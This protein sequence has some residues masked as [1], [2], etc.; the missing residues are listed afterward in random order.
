MLAV[1]ALAATL[2]TQLVTQIQARLDA[3]TSGDKAVWARDLDD[4]ALLMDEE[5]HVSTKAQFLAALAPLPKGST[6]S[7]RVTRPHFARTGDVVVIAFIAD[8]HETIYGQHFQAQFGMVDTYHRV[9]D[10]WLLLS[11]TQTRLPL[12]PPVAHL[13][14]AQAQRYVGRYRM[15][16]GPLVFAVRMA[17]GKLLG[18]RE[19]SAALPMSAIADQPNAFFR[20]GRPG[21]L[22]FVADSSGRIVKLIDRRYYNRDMIY[23]RVVKNA[24]P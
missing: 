14:T 12:D 5:G 23:E 7:L 13:T 17:G 15:L 3:I 4:A 2:E 21:T 19:G 22:I 10:R 18:G 24:R 9:G 1:L 16:E 6:G 8:E 20:E 11:D